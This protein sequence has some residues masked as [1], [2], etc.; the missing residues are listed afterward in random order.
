[1]NSESHHAYIGQ[2]LDIFAH[3]VCWKAYWS[4]KILPYLGKSVLEVGTGIGT[5][6]K[7]LL[8]QSITI[9]KWI[10]LEPDAGL[11]K[12]ILANING[13]H[14]SK[15]E[16]YEKRLDSFVTNEKFD[17]ILY[18]D[19]LEHIEDDMDEIELAMSFLKK[20][21]YLL[22]LVPAHNFLFSEFDKSIGHYRRYNKKLM[23]NIIPSGL[24]EEK[25]IYMDSIGMLSSVANKFVL[26]QTYP[27]I[28]Q[29]KFW[30]S[31][32][33]RMSKISDAIFM[34]QLG[35]SLLGIW[36]K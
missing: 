30:D 35:K 11:A 33:V 28:K 7:Y 17:A 6:T 23:R 1:M 34:H 32:I 29:I 21:G 20:G 31:T 2:E 5:N 18:I 8:E 26:K 4:K 36:K 9:R 19:V 10:C 25:L 27:S 15:V 13:S 12:Q 24:Q 22:V 14:K 3:A 16:V